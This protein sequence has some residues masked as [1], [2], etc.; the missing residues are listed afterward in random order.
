MVE[1][2]KYLDSYMIDYKER[3]R[4]REKSKVDSK[5]D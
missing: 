1:V 5:K 3:I 4:L 2:V